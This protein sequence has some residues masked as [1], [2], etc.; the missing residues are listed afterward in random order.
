MKRVRHAITTSI[1]QS[2]RV[3][4]IRLLLSVMS[5]SKTRRTNVSD[6]KDWRV[7]PSD[8]DAA[9]AWDEIMEIASKHCLVVQAYGGVATLAMPEEQ[10]SAGIR[11]RTLDAEEAREPTHA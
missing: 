8:A 7:T 2:F 9:K 5:P 10:R 6:R 1:V 11:Q 3:V 4:T